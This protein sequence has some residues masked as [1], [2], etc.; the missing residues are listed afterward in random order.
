IEALLSLQKMAMQSRKPAPAPAPIRS[1][2]E[3]EAVEK[4]GGAPEADTAMT[5]EEQKM[6]QNLKMIEFGTWF[7]F[8]GG[9]RLKVAWYNSKTMQ[10]MLVD[11]MGKKVAMKSGLELARGML[12]GKARVIAGS[13]KPFFE[14]ALE[15]I[16]QNLNAKAGAIQ[17]ESS[18][19]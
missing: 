6:V 2:L 19:V 11:Q 1:K 7:E 9:K 15:N 18:H 8:E 5:P 3:S 17:P 16:L 14:R 12:E 4:A 13:T 10:Y